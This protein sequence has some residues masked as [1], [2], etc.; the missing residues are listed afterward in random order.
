MMRL[1]KNFKSH[2]TTNAHTQTTKKERKAFAKSL[3]KV[4]SF[5]KS[6]HTFVA[7][8]VVDV[9]LVA[10][11]R[12]G[13]SSGS[14]SGGGA[15]RRWGGRGGGGDGSSGGRCTAT[16]GAMPPLKQHKIQE[17]NRKR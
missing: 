7:I 13:C 11:F 9:G 4:I 12:V 14:G 15:R 6:V 3:Q 8:I 2:V 1:K 5:S 16:I 10:L 17:I